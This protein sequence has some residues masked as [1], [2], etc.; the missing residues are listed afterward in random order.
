M[1]QKGKM[2]GKL[3]KQNFGS[4]Y[5]GLG[6]FWEPKA[7]DNENGREG[8]RLADAVSSEPDSGWGRCGQ[9]DPL[10]PPAIAWDGYRMSPSALYLPP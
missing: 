6:Q 8:E 1:L 5:K 4:G 10:A 2:I 9:A 3:G 7:L